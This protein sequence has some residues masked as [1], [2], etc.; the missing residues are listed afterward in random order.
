M[1][2]QSDKKKILIGYLSRTMKGSIPAITNVYVD[3]LRD[4]YTFIPFY[5]ERNFGK[6][7]LSSLN[8]INIYYFIKHFA[9]WCFKIIIK[10]PDIAHYP[11]TSNWNLEKSLL[12]LTAAKF[13]GVR[14]TIGHLHGGS[15]IEFWNR[16]PPVRKRKALRR[17]NNLD[18]FIVLSDSWKEK[19]IKHVG[20]KEDKIRV[21]FNVI[22][23]RFED[24]F[25]KF[26]RD[27]SKKAKLT[28]MGLNLLDSR[29]GIF[30]LLEAV[31]ILGNN[32]R[33]ELVVIGN[34]REPGVLAKITGIIDY[35]G[36]KN[37]TIRGSVWDEEKFRWFEKADILIL[38]SHIENFPVVIL[39]AAAAG[40]PVIASELGALPDV[41]THKSDILFIQPE[42][43]KALA[44]HIEYLLV[45]P[46]ERKRLGENI[47]STFNKKLTRT[48]IL[49][50]LME[51]YDNLG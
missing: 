11:V 15:F 43:S 24:H 19:I 12:F 41:F 32:K 38:P 26:R 29:K 16:L 48:R 28:L 23:T 27:Y 9:C 13:L 5:M 39:E 14:H 4:T 30:D 7:K 36:I 44:E 10:R 37:I 17:L 3:E 49:P 22:E 35:K 1:K 42:D 47:K 33:F 25:N 46:D 8:L 50:A 51:I 40:L 34:E 21:L 6:T 2:K 20:I 18:V 45:S 31:S